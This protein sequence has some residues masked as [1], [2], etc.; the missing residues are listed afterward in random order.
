VLLELLGTATLDEDT[1]LELEL[2]TTDELLGT[3]ALDEETIEELE[4]L[5]DE[6]LGKTLPL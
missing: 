1:T 5:T 4:L 3:T 6:L 2:G